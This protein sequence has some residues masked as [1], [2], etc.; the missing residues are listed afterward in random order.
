MKKWLSVLLLAFAAIIPMTSHAVDKTPSKVLIIYYSLTGNTDY[1]A[2]HLQKKTGADIF[3]VELLNP[4]PSDREQANQAIIKELQEGTL[5][6]LKAYPKNIASYDLILIGSPVWK[7]KVSTPVKSLLKQVD[8][9]GK[10]VA[11]FCTYHGQFGGF[12]DDFKNQAVNAVVLDG[13]DIKQPK[14]QDEAAINAS[15]DAWLKKIQN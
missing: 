1:I 6:A 9:Q 10:K 14:N 7:Y 8:F 3:K 13:L 11:A 12:F 5:P 4:Y 15:L 2:N